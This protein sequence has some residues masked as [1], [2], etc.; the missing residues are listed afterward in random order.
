MEDQM[1]AGALTSQ[2][3]WKAR[4]GMSLLSGVLFQK[5]VEKKDEL[6][7]SHI[8]WL[9]TRTTSKKGIA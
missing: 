8:V 7:H 2:N 6:A 1:V 5:G 9:C 3:G 4:R